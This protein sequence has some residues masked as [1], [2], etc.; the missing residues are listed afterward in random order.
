MNKKYDNFNSNALRDTKAYDS[1][2]NELNYF[3]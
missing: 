1:Y 3:Y 2:L